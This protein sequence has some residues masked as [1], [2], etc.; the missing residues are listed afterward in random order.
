MNLPFSHAQFLDVFGAYNTTLWGAVLVLWI[1][2]AG[3]LVWW[4]R[5]PLRA[6]GLLITLLA[7]H[8]VWSGVMY[9]WVFFRTIN[10]AASAFA[11]LFVLEAVI[12]IWLRATGRL[13][14]QRAGGLR[15]VAASVLVGYTLIYP[16][17]G[18]MTGLRYPRMPVFGVPCP[19]DILTCG[20]LLLAGRG[21]RLAGLVPIVWAAIGGSAAFALGIRPD[22]MLV[23]AG[24]L[25]LI[26]A[27]APAALGSAEPTWIDR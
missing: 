17:V 26:Q 8:W 18:M 3:A 13:Y 22:L 4:I 20:L 15:G 11:G 9:H 21:A 1:V 10:P 2:T 19:T 12:L 27:I 14:F 5:R 6:G 7:V 23:V 16:V 24:L 25:L